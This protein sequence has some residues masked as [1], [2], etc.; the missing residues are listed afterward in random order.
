MPVGGDACIFHDDAVFRN[1]FL[2]ESS[3]LTV[4]IVW[5]ESFHINNLDEL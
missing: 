1:V 2:K 5:T 3:N 4:Y